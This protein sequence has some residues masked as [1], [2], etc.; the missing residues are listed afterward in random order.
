MKK[1]C[2]L[3]LLSL[4][5]TGCCGNGIDKSRHDDTLSVALDITRGDQVLSKSEST[6]IVSS[7]SVELVADNTKIEAQNFRYDIEQN[8]PVFLFDPAIK[9]KEISKIYIELFDMNPLP[10][11]IRISETI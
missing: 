10:L 8:L 11:I 6:S 2:T 7:V 4:S 9:S 3:V 1:L 5:L